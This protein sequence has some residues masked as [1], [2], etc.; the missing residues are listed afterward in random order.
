[1]RRRDFSAILLIAGAAMRPALAQ[2]PTKQRRIA[3]VAAA[4]AP[5]AI[6]EAGSGFGVPSLRSCAV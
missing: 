5:E 3:I 6:S 1:M 2:A 4:G